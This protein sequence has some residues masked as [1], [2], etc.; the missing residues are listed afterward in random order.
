MDVNV[1]GGNR[2]QGV[3]SSVGPRGPKGDTGTQGPAGQPGPA[4]AAG[5]AGTTSWDGIDGKPS[6]FVP[7]RHADDHAEGGMDQVTL[8]MG[9]ITGL[10][11]ALAGKAASSHTHPQTAI[12][13]ILGTADLAGDITQ[14]STIVS[15]L[16]TAA[17]RDVPDAESNAS[18]GQAVLG[19]DTRL[20][21]AREWTA[22]T[23]SQAEAEAGSATTRRAWTAQRV[24]QAVA[25]WWAASSAKTKLDGI[26]S[27]A[28]AN[29][30][31][32]QLR[33]RATHTGTQAVAT[34]TGL[35]TALDG[36]AAYAQ[37]ATYA[38]MIAL[39]TPAVLT[40]VRV[41]ADENKGATNTVYQ[42]WPNGSRL[43]IAALAD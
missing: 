16:G 5:P 17:E 20:T 10:S 14:L 32:A 30:T 37:V 25:A 12:G 33:D 35:Q 9:Q 3:V 24:S 26:S 27:G 4:G 23:V 29:A 34:V 31:D 13:S 6:E 1:T 21:N 19:S 22:S 38:A 15:T 2:I 43:W 7:R 11:S 40:T 42:L 39:G 36:K 28:T 18:A 8:S 41:T